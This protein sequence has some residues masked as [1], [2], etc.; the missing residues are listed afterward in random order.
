[1][2]GFEMLR[3][4]RAL[5]SLRDTP[6]MML[7][8]GDQSAAR[9]E[10]LELGVTTCLMKPVKPS[11]LLVFVRQLLSTPVV[12]TTAPA[13]RISHNKLHILLAEDNRVNQKVATGM[14]E[15]AGHRVAVANNGAEAVAKWRDG[16]FDLILMDV[17]MPDVDGFEAARE[18]RKQEKA[19]G[20][21]VPIVALTAHAM[22]GDRERCLEVGMDDYLS[23]PI[24]R[25]ELLDLLERWG[26]RRTV[27]PLK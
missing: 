22:A 10:C 21:H 2:D 25:E 11:V 1:M 16:A 4:V 13:G 12:E 15:R 14:L 23:K 20:R 3:K 19:G 8:S 9:A 26:A 18:I 6:I 24:R 7:S 27:E 5:A 17:Q